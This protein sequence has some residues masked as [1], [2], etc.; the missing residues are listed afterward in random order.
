MQ[1]EYIFYFFPCPVVNLIFLKELGA[2]APEQKCNY[3]IA[4][5]QREAL[6]G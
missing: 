1:N 4:R 2:K 5:I 6:E 3:D